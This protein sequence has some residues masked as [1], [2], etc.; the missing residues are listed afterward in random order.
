ML[1]FAALYFKSKNM[2]SGKTQNE[3][4]GYKENAA[5]TKTSQILIQHK[6]SGYACTHLFPGDT[7]FLMQRK[8]PSM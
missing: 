1:A 3:K 6:Y 2:D 5:M 8:Y 7:K 4:I